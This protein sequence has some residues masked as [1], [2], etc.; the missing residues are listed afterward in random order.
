[1]YCFQ[2]NVSTTYESTTLYMGR[3]KSVSNNP[4]GGDRARTGSSTVNDSG[5]EAGQM[6]SSNCD[7]DRDSALFQY[8]LHRA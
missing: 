2:Y 7:A 8:A 6:G 4:G 1:M 5:Q 3:A